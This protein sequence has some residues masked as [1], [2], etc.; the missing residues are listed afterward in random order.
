MPDIVS[1]EDMLPGRS[2]INRQKI[3]GT[4]V[5][6]SDVWADNAG[7]AKEDHPNEADD[8]KLVFLEPFPALI[9]RRTVKVFF[10]HDSL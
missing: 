7:K 2:L 4:I 1:P 6:R 3:A 5:I 9:K 8:G 10:L